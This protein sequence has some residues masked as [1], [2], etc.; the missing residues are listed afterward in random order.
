MSWGEQQV[1]HIHQLM[2]DE[3]ERRDIPIRSL[4]LAFEARLQRTLMSREGK[5][6]SYRPE[7]VIAKMN[8]PVGTHEMMTFD[9]SWVDPWGY[10]HHE[11]TRFVDI[12]LKVMD[13]LSFQ[14]LLRHI[15]QR[16][17][18]LKVKT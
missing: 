2:S 11:N 18:A 14:R 5:Q 3:S 6:V 1:A 9:V 13:E 15:Q 17:Q 10:F 12:N 16:K 8:L 7:G 4:R